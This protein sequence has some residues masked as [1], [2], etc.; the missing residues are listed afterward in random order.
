[1]ERKHKG[2]R[3]ESGKPFWEPGDSVGESSEENCNAGCGVGNSLE[4]GRDWRWG[5]HPH[6]SC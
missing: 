5:D 2:L 1:M 6:L 3:Y 4:K